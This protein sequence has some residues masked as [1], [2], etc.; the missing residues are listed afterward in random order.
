MRKQRR[1]GEKFCPKGKKNTRTTHFF[2]VK[3]SSNGNV[4]YFKYTKKYLTGSFRV[5]IAQ[6]KDT[7]WERARMLT[8]VQEGNVATSG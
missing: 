6:G 3:V 4:S 8:Y 5:K 2:H 7:I 1:H